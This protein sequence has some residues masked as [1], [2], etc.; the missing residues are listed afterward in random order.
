VDI[1]RLNNKVSFLPFINSRF[2]YNT[3][4][5]VLNN[6]PASIDLAGGQYQIGYN[7]TDQFYYF[8]DDWRVRDNLTLNIGVRYEYTGQPIN[9]LNDLTAERESNPQNALWRQN[10]PL[11]ARTFAKL[12]ADKNNF[13]PRLGFAWRPRLGDSSLSK[14]LLGEQDS[15]VISGGYSMAYDA[16]FYNLLLNA[17]TSAPTAF[18]LNVPA[19][20][21]FP[22][23]SGVPTGENVAQAARAA[24]ALQVNAYDPKFFSRTTF[25]SDF[26]SPYVQQWTLRVQREISR[27]NVVEARYVGSKTTGL[28]QTLNRNPRIDRLI[29]GFTIAGITFPG[30]PNLVPQGITP[31][32]AGQGGCVDNPATPVN[33]STLCAGRVFAAGLVRSRENTANATYHGL[34]TRYEG[35]LLNQVSVGLSYTW[36]KALDNASEV[37]SFF[38]SAAPQNPFDINAGEKGYSGFD[39]R[40]AL[41]MNFIWDVPAFKDQKGIVGKALGGWQLSGTYFLASGQRFTPAQGF[42]SLFF[43]LG[44]N[45]ALY[46]G[47][48][49]GF[50]SLRPF[51]GNPNAPK[52]SVGISQI[53]AF[54]LY[55]TAIEKPDG[56]YDLVELNRSNGANAVEVTKDQVR[57]IVG[58]WGAAKIFGTPYGNVPRGAEKGPRLNDLALG[59]FKN[60]R[61][62]ETVR[63]QFRLDMFNALNHPNPG[64]G[65]N[66]AAAAGTPGGFVEGTLL[67]TPFND[68]GEVAQA[69]RALQ[70]GLKVIF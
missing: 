30:F 24:G 54:L 26:Y 60:T 6:T 67:A 59:I 69:R 56:F 47:T 43:G 31:Q 40:H 22:L 70:F 53:D 13:A 18:L 28:F 68:L 20:A 45:D 32:V 61:I 11:E 38:E 44:Y 58:G 55:G 66:A 16:S 25:S 52:T 33:E 10:L 34:Q 48:F 4:A 50:D 62:T 65:F 27:N 39:R 3:A 46:D 8:Q 1:R 37:F 42:S 21:A 57:Y 12:P 15:T 51:Y 29:N 9:T 14:W 63:L 19:A 36:S 17:S 5:R 2:S 23:P 35:R 41:A 49:I 7:E 64:V